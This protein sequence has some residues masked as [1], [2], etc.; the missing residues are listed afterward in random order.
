[1]TNNPFTTSFGIEPQNYIKRIDETNRII[2][3]FSS[4]N[5]SN[6]VY[7]ITGIRG[8]GKTVLLSSISSYFNKLDDWI[9]VDPGSKENILENIAS[10]IYESSKIKQYFLKKEFSFSFKGLSFSIEG[11]NPVSSVQTLLKKML[12]IIDKKGQ[13]VLIT[14]DEVDNSEQMKYFIQAFESLMRQKYPVRLLMTGLYNNISKLQED[15]SITF[16]YRAPKIYLNNLNISSITLSY[17]KYL[18]INEEKALSFA[19]LTKGYAYAYQVLGYI[20]YGKEKRELDYDLLIEFDQYL[21]DYVY[22][23]LYSELSNKEQSILEQIDTDKDIK[24]SDLTSSTNIDIKTLSV[25]RDRLIKKGILIS[26]S[27]GYVALA[28]P[29]F[30]NFLDTKRY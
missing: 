13:K 28:L 23:K 1:M 5:P 11:N 16:L 24:M 30:N 21:Q 12:S 19:R 10:E 20:L 15:S 8:S 2:G 17:M 27:Y 7:I 6:Y 29:R 25:Y 18:N 26:P 9:V 4:D 3:D 14:I 22:E